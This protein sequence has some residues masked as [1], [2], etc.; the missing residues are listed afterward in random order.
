M[1]KNIDLKS[2]KLKTLLQKYSKRF[3]KHIIFG[4][5][6]VVLIAYLVVVLRIS[7]LAKAEPGPDQQD[8]ITS[9]IP[10]IDKNAVNQIQNL[11]Q[12]NTQIHSLFEQARNNPFQE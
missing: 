7:V 9:S 3:S 11:E 5:I 4:A 12:N 2:V 1:S 8:T 6:F 10:K